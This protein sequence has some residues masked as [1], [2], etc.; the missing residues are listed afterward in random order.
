MNLGVKHIKSYFKT[1]IASL[2]DMPEL[3]SNFPKADYHFF[4]LLSDSACVLY[5][6][7]CP[8]VTLFYSC[9]ATFLECNEINT[10]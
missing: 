3:F 5:I 10:I 8:H 7:L 9:W 6:I 4:H 1:E 2:S